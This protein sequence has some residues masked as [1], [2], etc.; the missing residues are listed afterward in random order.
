M[1]IIAISDTHGKHRDLIIP[2]G[3]VLVHAGD[4][5]SRGTKQQVIDFLEWFVEQNHV[6]KI[7][8]AGNHDFLFEQAEF[9][10][11]SRIIPDGI[12]YLNDSSVVINGFKFWGSPIT[13]WF[14]NWAFNRDRGADIKKH[15]DLIPNDTDVL[16]THG[17]PVGILDQTFYGKRTG[18]EDLLSRVHQV[19]PKYHIFGHIHEQY[20]NVTK[21]ETTFVNASVLDDWYEMKN[22][23]IILNL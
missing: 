6:H 9:D 10:E 5:S 1:Q 8:I 13:P 11:I 16:I 3:D 17:P 22:N 2:D 4:I 21:A 14:N 19:K 18:C 7:F 15:W 20:G 23:P 12:M